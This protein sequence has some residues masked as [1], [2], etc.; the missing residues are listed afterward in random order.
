MIRIGTAYFLTMG[1]A[2]R[3]YRPLDYSRSDVEQ[4]VT[5]GTIHIGRPPLKPGE[6]LQTIDGGAR[7]AVVSP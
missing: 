5:D 4:M 2:A 3:Y 6:Q 7:W 1:S